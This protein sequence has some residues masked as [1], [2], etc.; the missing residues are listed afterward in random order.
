[1][2]IPVHFIGSIALDNPDE[3]FA[4]AGELLGPH[5]KRMP[6]GEL[7]GRRLWISWQIPV[8]RAHPDLEV[9]GEQAG[10]MGLIPLKLR[11]G[12]RP[13]DL[14]FGELG[15]S[16]EARASYQDFLAARRAGVLPAGVRFQVSLPSPAAIINAFCVQPDAQLILPASASTS[17]TA[18]STPCTS[19]SR[20]MP[21]R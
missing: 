21:P 2:T 14:H 4:T 18:T 6:D 9:A 3:V 13:E 16:R 19:S 1:M 15:Y 20:P 17:A 12:V 8:L 10:T 11:D 7:G 5:L